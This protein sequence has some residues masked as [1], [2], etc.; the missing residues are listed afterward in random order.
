MLSYNIDKMR[1]SIVDNRPNYIDDSAAVNDW[2]WL[3]QYN[4]NSAFT[5]YIE[6]ILEK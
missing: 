3:P 4:L 2:G 1:Q 6:P 5:E